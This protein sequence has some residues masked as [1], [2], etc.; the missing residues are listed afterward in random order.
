MEYKV[1]AIEQH[2]IYN[3]AEKNEAWFYEWVAVNKI[4]VVLSAPFVWCFNKIAR[5][6]QNECR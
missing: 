3:L 5:R 4:L 2:R 1:W 6:K